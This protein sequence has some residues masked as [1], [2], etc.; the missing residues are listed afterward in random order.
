MNCEKMARSLF[1]RL[2]PLIA[3][4]LW[5]ANSYGDERGSALEQYLADARNFWFLND[6]GRVIDAL[7]VSPHKCGKL[8]I[9][10]FGTG[11]LTGWHRHEN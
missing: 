1:T 3:A 5:L 4:S 9:G 7:Y 6:T 10:H 8:G 11:D 2:V